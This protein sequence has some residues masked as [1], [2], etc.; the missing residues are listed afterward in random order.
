MGP[1]N[2]VSSVIL[3]V[4][5]RECIGPTRDVFSVGNMSQNAL[6]WGHVLRLFF[7]SLDVFLKFLTYF[8]HFSDIHVNPFRMSEKQNKTFPNS[9]WYRIAVFLLGVL[10]TSEN[11]R[12]MNAVVDWKNFSSI[13]LYFYCMEKQSHAHKPSESGAGGSKYLRDY[14]LLTFNCHNDVTSFHLPQTTSRRACMRIM[15]CF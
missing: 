7:R 6:L 2:C 8:F 12:S 4:T 14:S 3:P 11:L 15:F 13:L 9:I 5:A 10:L 1:N